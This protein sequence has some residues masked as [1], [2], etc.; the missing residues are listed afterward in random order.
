MINLTQWLCPE[1]H[2]IIAYVWD[3]ESNTE[4]NMGGYW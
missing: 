1:R 2:G 4:G 3:T